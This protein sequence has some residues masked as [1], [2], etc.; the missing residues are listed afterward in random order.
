MPY[1]FM[2]LSG[3]LRKGSTNSAVL[4]TALVLAPAGV[5]PVVYEGVGSLP[6]YNPDHDVDP[7]DEAVDGF[8]AEIHRAH[9]IVVSTPEYAGALP[10]IVQE[11]PG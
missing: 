9:A 4:R 2:L 6:H 8:R 1:R 7:L 10:R 5:E 11:R 3:S